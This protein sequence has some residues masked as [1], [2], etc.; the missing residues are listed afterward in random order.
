M[1]TVNRP[2][3][4]TPLLPRRWRAAYCCGRCA[5]VKPA[6][7]LLRQNPAAVAGALWIA[8]PARWR[9]GRPLA[10]PSGTMRWRGL[11]HWSGR[12]HRRQPPHGKSRHSD[13]G[14]AVPSLPG[15]P[16]FVRS[17]CHRHRDDPVKNSQRILSTDHDDHP[18][19]SSLPPQLLFASIPWGRCAA[20][21]PPVAV[22]QRRAPAQCR[23]R[24]VPPSRLL[25]LAFPGSAP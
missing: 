16:A 7:L 14:I 25:P 23:G 1:M 8:R 2:T 22:F 10:L 12:R 17:L 18:K 3:S 9:I 24:D 5:A 11:W 4:C 20:A 15:L 21:T 13:P 19:Q 6:P